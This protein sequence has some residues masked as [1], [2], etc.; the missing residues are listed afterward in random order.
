MR[1]EVI[2]F[3]LSRTLT[4]ILV[5]LICLPYTWSAIS[6][7]LEIINTCDYKYSQLCIAYLFLFVITFIYIALGLLC[8][9]ACLKDFKYWRKIVW[10]FLVLSI[11]IVFFDFYKS[12]GSNIMEVI[13]VKINNLQII[14]YKGVFTNFIFL[15]LKDIFNPIVIFILTL[16][17]IFKKT[18]K[19]T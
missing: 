19:Q 11:S 7:T 2:N 12:S 6:L 1:S 16:V 3:L 8:V 14:L 15:V 18:N 13:E 5:L 17:M 9:L 4:A 10:T